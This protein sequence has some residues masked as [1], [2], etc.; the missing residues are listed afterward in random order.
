MLGSG[1]FSKQGALSKGSLV[2]QQGPACPGVHGIR[3]ELGARGTNACGT[4]RRAAMRPTRVE[5]LPPAFPLLSPGSRPVRALERRARAHTTGRAPCWASPSWCANAHTR[6]VH[7]R[8]VVASGEPTPVCPQR[9]AGCTVGSAAA[10]AAAP[11]RTTHPRK[12]AAT[13][14]RLKAFASVPSPSFPPWSICSLWTSSRKGGRAPQSQAASP[15]APLLGCLSP[16]QRVFIAAAFDPV[17]WARSKALARSPSCFPRCC[18][19]VDDRGLMSN[20]LRV[21]AC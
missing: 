15:L 19:P 17:K 5:R 3:P 4:S 9:L 14:D 1:G 8:D 10:A 12:R 2:C 6:G 16:L 13:Q 7:A 20:R 11:P 18:W 21:C